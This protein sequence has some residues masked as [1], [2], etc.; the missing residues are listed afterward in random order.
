M[1]TKLCFQWDWFNTH[2]SSLHLGCTSC[3][4]INFVL[5]IQKEDLR[6]LDEKYKYNLNFVL[7]VVSGLY[8]KIYF[9]HNKI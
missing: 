2:S 4:F 1:K 3:K 6:L 8:K 7:T 9:W 5:N